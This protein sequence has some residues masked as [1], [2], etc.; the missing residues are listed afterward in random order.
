MKE[1]DFEVLNDIKYQMDRCTCLAIHYVSIV[2]ADP[3]KEIIDTPESREILRRL[4]CNLI[5]ENDVLRVLDFITVPL[6]FVMGEESDKIIEKT[7]KVIESID[8]S[9]EDRLLY[10][11]FR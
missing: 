4:L 1:I 3:G 10:A 11:I 9:F 6:K 5:M 8:I 7:K 2:T